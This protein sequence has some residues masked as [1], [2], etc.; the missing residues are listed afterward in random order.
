MINVTTEEFLKAIFKEDL[1]WVHVTD[2]PYPPDAIPSNRHLA[3]WKGDY[4]SRYSFSENTNKYFTISTFYAD[5]KGVARR[6]KALYR[7]THC[8]VLDD[9]REKLSEEAAA[10]LPEPS[11]ILETSKDSFQWGYILSTPCTVAAQIDNLNDGLIA[12]DL[13][14]SG[15]DP[16]QRGITRF[17]RTPNAINNKTSKLVNGEPW[18]CILRLWKPENTVSLEQLAMPFNINLNASRRESRVDG[19]AS[20]P[21]HPLLQIPD[22]IHIKE[23]RSDGRMDVTCPWVDE[24]TGGDDSGSAVFTNADGSF[25]FK[26]HHGACQERTGKHLIEKIEEEKSGFRAMLK[27]WQVR[28]QLSAVA[29]RQEIDFFNVGALTSAP[30]QQEVPPVLPAPNAGDALSDAM[31]ALRREIPSTSEARDMAEKLLKLVD[32]LPQMEKIHWHAEIC[33]QMRWSKPDFKEI[34]RDL[35]AV[36]YANK[37]KDTDF[38]DK[39][40]FVRELNQFYAWES[41]IFY[42]AEAFHNSF[43]HIDP[44]A[45]TTALQDGRV[46][47]VDRLDYAPRCPRTFVEKGITYGNTWSDHCEIKGLEGDVTRWL[48]HWDALGWGHHRKHML[49][50]MAYTIRHPEKK[51]NHMLILGGGE[52]CGKDFLLHP[53][54]TA[55]GDNSY[56]IS[57][58][59]LLEG[60]N[61]YLLGTKYLHINETELGD[62]REALMVSNKLKPYAAAPPNHI[63]VNQKNVKQVK[64]RNIVNATMTT[65]SQTPI[66]TTGM[67]RRFY[68]VWSDLNTRD[69]RMNV[70]PEWQSYWED[71]WGWMDAGGVEACIWYLRNCVDLSD[72]NPSIAPEVTDFMREIHESSK[73]A[74]QQTL[75]AFIEHRI[76]VFKSDIVTL[77]E[78]SSTLRSA[79]FVGADYLY[80]DSKIFTPSRVSNLLKQMPTCKFIRAR[81]QYG[82]KRVWIIRNLHQY[83]DMTGTE[84]YDHYETQMK[85]AKAAHPIEIVRKEA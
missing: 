63:R 49:Q 18:R 74:P 2:F 34:L 35:R 38:Y 23:V 42:T 27:D 43:S 12:S 46:T 68:A 53:L 26:C 79:E 80:C 28:R 82:E 8:V 81:R 15:K 21:D 72:F 85:A 65:N 76:G 37:V 64:V 48:A 36:W 33:D 69:E 56:V 22:L 84:V 7:Q 30:V 41:R 44:D 67:S 11:W 16:G 66:K 45:R 17:C 24:H 1:P 5:E 62:R 57:G 29:S 47:K 58:D 61:D 25:G 32:D 73:T 6:R 14:P 19:A 39:V 77:Q 54:I 31:S 60:W 4:Y 10:R 59:D 3:A 71:R 50:W 55:M 75:E 13:A 78:A 51:I 9:V 40:M 52:G 20:V 83:R 70:L